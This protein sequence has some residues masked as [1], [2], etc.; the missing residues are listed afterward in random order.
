ME[1]KIKILSTTLLDPAIIEKAVLHNVVLDA[2]DFI[3]T[4]PVT[5]ATTIQ[6]ITT[7]LANPSATLVFTS[8][9]AVKAVGAFVVNQLQYKIFCIGK[10]TKKAVENFFD[11]SL[12]QSWANDAEELAKEIIEYNTKEVTFFCGNK[13]LDTL[14]AILHQ[15]GINVNEV[16]VYNTIENPTCI[17]KDYDGVLFFS[18]S[19]VHSFFTAN[20]VTKHTILFAIGHTTADALKKVSNNKIVISSL[21]S[22]GQVVGEAIE[23]FTKLAIEKH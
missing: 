23:Y 20:K 22:K 18:P 6:R 8:A 7:A 19:C 12:I 5:D 17:H 21:P 11:S 13:R 15:A 14:P 9:N 10:A 1:N 2:I 16:I 3:T 4:A